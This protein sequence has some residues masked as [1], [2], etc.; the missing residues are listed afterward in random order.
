[1]SSVAEPPAARPRP[2]GRTI[3]IAL[4]DVAA[5]PA[6][7]AGA[8]VGLFVAAVVAT[9]GLRLER[10]TDVLIGFML[11]GAALAA[12]ALLRR[13]R[14][15]ATPMYGGV[16]LLAFGLLAGFTALSITWSLSP[17]DSYLET[18][19][20]LSYVAL[21]AGGIALARLAPGSWSGMVTGIGAGCVLISCWA[22]LTKVFPATLA[23]AE[24]FA[25]LREP[26]EYWN[27]VG[28]MAALGVPPMLWLAA[29]RTGHAAANALAWPALGLLLT[30]VML[31]YSRGSLVALAVGLA[32]WFAI[33]PLRLRSL[34]ALA[35]GV[36]GCALVVMW[37]FAQDGL[38]TD[39]APMSARVD[40]G[41]EFGPLLLLMVTVLLAAG[42]A[43]QFVTAQ[44]APSPGARRAAGWTAGGVLALV[45][46]VA[47]IALATASGGVSGQVSKAWHQLTDVNART[48]A[49]TPNRLTATSSVRARYWDEALKIHAQSPWVG[50]GAGSYVVARTRFRKDALAVRQAHGY[51]VQTL[52]DLG[53]VGLALSLFAA[54]AW[55]FAAARA[56][57]LRRRDRGLHWD[58]ERVGLAAL[59]VVVLEFGVHS[60]VDWT[61]FVPANAAA[62]ML[63]AGWVA[64]RAPLAARLGGAA[65]PPGGRA[66]GAAGRFAWLR[67]A[68]RGPALGAVL[69][70]VLALTAS[71]AA[72]QPVRSVHAQDAAYD[73]L[74]QGQPAA[75]VEVAQLAVRR[76]PLSVDALF[77]LAAIQQARGKLSDARNA[78]E[79]AV[80]LQPADAETWRRLG[81]LRLSELHDSKG[82]LN[83]FR[84]AYFLDPASPQSV[85]DVLEAARAAAGG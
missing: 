9:G 14:T 3:T 12:A 10:T 60:T 28:L 85:S 57:G 21:F 52:A 31:S 55:L 72:Y 5:T 2:G 24:T 39:N 82:A 71:W 65:V 81:R 50:T 8:A 79:R 46:V 17:S 15:A 13:P 45:P 7:A 68:E 38:T 18:G 58:A 62:A 11:A 44:R 67:G 25:R 32:A 66:P 61:W 19:R 43:A 33:V 37:T 64:G 83:A 77:Q 59:A 54:G 23:P 1:V 30:C 27:S 73:R 74:D 48:P 84:A 34:C 6:I 41:H 20:T 35:A 29:R 63:C 40:S 76:D 36:A 47:L 49:N 4:P 56:I 42:L 70:V 22:L 51:V 69:V 78:L 26:F 53:W 80:H 16:A 75:A